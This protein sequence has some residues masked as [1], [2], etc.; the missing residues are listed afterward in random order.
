MSQYH[1]VASSLN[2][3]WAPT[4]TTQVRATA[5][6]N[7]AAIGLPGAY[8]FYLIPN[9]GKQS[10]QDLYVSTLIE[11]QTTDNWHS[12]VRYGLARKREQ[13]EQW[14]AAGIPIT[15][16][17]FGSP[18]LNYYGLPVLIKGANGYQVTGQAQL[19]SGFGT[20]PNASDISSNRDQLYAQTDYKITP[21]LTALGSFLYE[22]ER[23]SNNYPTYDISQA[24]ER[25]NYEYTAQFSGQFKNRV[26]YQLGGGLQKNHLYGVKGTPRA[27]VAYYLQRPGA[28]T[29][30]GTKLTF[31]FSKGVQ[32]PS[33]SDQFGSL[34]DTLLTQPGGEQAIEQ[35]HISQIGAE[36]A[37]TYDGGVEQ[38]MLSEKMLAARHLLPQRIR[39]PDRV[40]GLLP[41]SATASRADARPTAGAGRRAPKIPSALISTRLRSAPRASKPRFSISPLPIFSFAPDT[42]ISTPRCSN[43][44][45]RTR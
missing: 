41:Y 5:R 23:G 10:D 39:Q 30:Q 37:R 17:Q 43:P 25:G 38:S 3:G 32:E 9:D 45:R 26:Y 36:Q 24:A 12:F 27:G 33:L 20:Y 34:Y 16:I 28:G 14:Y 2:L 19:N 15:T 1:N 18:T 31:N 4:S 21:Y 13:A 35:A 8:D 7:T 11:N 22:S 42:P 44:S 6:N 29:F 40:R